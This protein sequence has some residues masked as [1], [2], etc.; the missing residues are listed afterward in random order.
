MFLVTVQI[1]RSPYAHL[2][3]LETNNLI[4][5]NHFQIHYFLALPNNILKNVADLLMKDVKPPLL[6]AHN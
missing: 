5:S 6:M 1:A 2:V 4:F 3:N